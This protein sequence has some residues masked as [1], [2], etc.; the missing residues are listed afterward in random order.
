MMQQAVPLFMDWQ[1]KR[2]VRDRL[3]DQFRTKFHQVL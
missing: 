3:R 2:K 1:D